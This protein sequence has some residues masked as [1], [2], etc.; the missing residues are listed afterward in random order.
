LP[1]PQ[2]PEFNDL[3][4][5]ELCLM[6]SDLLILAGPT[7]GLDGPVRIYRWKDALATTT[8]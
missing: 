7:M 3:G 5:R 2:A 4:V 1:R 8:E 6:N